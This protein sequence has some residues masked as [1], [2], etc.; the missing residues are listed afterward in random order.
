MDLKGFDVSMATILSCIKPRSTER[1]TIRLFNS[2]ALF[3][4][5]E[6][7][8]TIED[9]VIK[10]DEIKLKCL[11]FCSLNIVDFFAR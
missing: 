8:L 7:P 4:V 2:T 1:I 10:F 11:K 3:V 9:V 5:Y 6:W